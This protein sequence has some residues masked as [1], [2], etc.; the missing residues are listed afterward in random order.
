MEI[1][2]QIFYP[3]SESYLLKK[4]SQINLEGSVSPIC[5]CR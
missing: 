4:N 5:K 3:Q 1:E 2:E